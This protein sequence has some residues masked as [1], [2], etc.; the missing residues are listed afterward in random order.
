MRIPMGSMRGLRWGLKPYQSKKILS[1]IPIF[2]REIPI[3]RDIPIMREIPIFRE[4]PIMRDIPIMR[5]I[6]MSRKVPSGEKSPS[7]PLYDIL[8]W[9]INILLL[10]LL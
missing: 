8:L 6:P 9:L 2:F 10:L 4:I 5:E 7:Q 3:L 1:E